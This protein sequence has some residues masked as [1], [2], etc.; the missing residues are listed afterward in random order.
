[1]A[2]IIKISVDTG[3][4]HFELADL[5]GNSLGV[6]S[7]NPTN[8]GMLPKLQALLEWFKS[9]E[10]S[11]N[12]GNAFEEIPRLNNEICKRIDE[13]FCASISAV[14]FSKIAPLSRTVDGG[15]YGSQVLEK[16]T[17]VVRQYTVADD[18][19]LEQVEAATAKYTA[20]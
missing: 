5:E 18:K 17:D 2:E 12:E 16:L 10:F 13:A 6:I 15:F 11:A 20:R 19:K 4:R 7:F 14:A 8:S 3:I 9:D 1:M